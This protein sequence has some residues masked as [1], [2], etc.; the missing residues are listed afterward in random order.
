MTATRARVTAT[1]VA[2]I[3]TAAR[4]AR[5]TALRIA[6]AAHLQATVTVAARSRAIDMAARRSPA[7][8]TRHRRATAAAHHT[9]RRARTAARRTLGA[10]DRVC[11]A[12][13]QLPLVLLVL[14]MVLESAMYTAVS[15]G[16]RPKPHAGPPIRRPL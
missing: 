15:C 5:A 14:S 13:V 9:A 3:V 11:L 12:L 6:T 1:E 2:P 16:S 8:A 10:T 4:R 7:I